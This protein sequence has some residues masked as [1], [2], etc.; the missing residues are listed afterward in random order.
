V[1][2]N[3]TPYL[4]LEKRDP[5][6]KSIH[7]ITGEER[8]SNLF[9]SNV[10]LIGDESITLIDAG[11]GCE[12]NRIA[13]ALQKLHLNIENVVN[14]VL[15]H[16]HDD[17]WGGLAELLQIIPVTVMVYH[18]DVA[19]YQDEI[20]RLQALHPYR[21]VGLKE[22]DIVDAEGH[23]LTVVHTPG[24]DDGS[25]CLYDE[26]CKILFS[27]DSV[28]ASGTTGSARSGNIDDMKK[29]LKRLATMDVDILLP[30]HGDIAFEN[31]NEAIQ[32]ALERLT[33]SDRAPNNTPYWMRHYTIRRDR[34]V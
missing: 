23:R 29:S 17:H 33:W 21:I 26:T 7:L 8:Y 18:E 12:T 13:P 22:G 32:L 25:I 1:F 20:R 6:L 24:H 3:N 28:F 4:K 5:R 31:A 11:D 15:T 30:G 19:Y 16:S 34:N 27:G 2:L 14:V 9:S 10:Y